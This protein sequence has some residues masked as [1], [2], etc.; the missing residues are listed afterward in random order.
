M[1]QIEQNCKLT[2]KN[3]P[4]NKSP[5][6]LRR[7]LLELATQTGPVYKVTINTSSISAS[8]GK[9]S[10]NT[11]KIDNCV[12]DFVYEESVPYAVKCLA[13]TKLFGNVLQYDY[14]KSNRETG[15]SHQTSGNSNGASNNSNKN[16]Y[17]QGGDKS[18][19]NCEKIW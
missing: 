19:Q 4:Q 12:V 15:V 11:K 8:R 9:A 2:I 10:S 14:D 7:L 18:R 17:W 16:L 1:D 6:L 3:L 13:G 5:D